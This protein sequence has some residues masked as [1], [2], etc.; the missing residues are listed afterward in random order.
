MQPY[1]YVVAGPN[2]VGKST[3]A[4]QYLPVGLELINSDDI[5]RQIRQEQAHQEVI[6]R[7]TNDEAQRRINQHV[8]KREMFAVETNLHDEATWQYF[9]SFRQLGYSF[10]LLFL[11]VD[12]I[13]LLQNRVLIRHMQGGH[14]VRNDV[15]RGRY[16]SGLA[17]LNHFFTEPD[18]LTLIDG[19]NVPKL[20]YQRVEGRVTTQ[21]ETLPGWVTTY[22]N[23]H[24]Q[25]NTQTTQPLSP[26]SIEEARARYQELKKNK[27]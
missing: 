26:L 24:F 6:Q 22:L 1:F 15:I 11:C 25:P 20:I 9:L 19:G 21:S 17:L 13:R 3:A 18:T 4:F 8:Q 16:E 2:G 23:D 14:F 12:D 5:A 7:L 10:R 27:P